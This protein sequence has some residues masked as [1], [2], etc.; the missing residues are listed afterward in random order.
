MLVKCILRR[1][2]QHQGTLQVS[3]N[4]PQLSGYRGEVLA[5]QG[6]LKSTT[7]AF[8]SIEE[9]LYY[10]IINLGRQIV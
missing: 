6:S 8:Q 1:F 5:L 7:A 2:P 4:T 3:Q 9:P 10:A